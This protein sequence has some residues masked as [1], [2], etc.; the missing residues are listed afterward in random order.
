MI[1]LVL[2]S[3]VYEI[4]IGAKVLAEQMADA[5]LRIEAVGGIP[6]TTAPHSSLGESAS[7][8]ST[9]AVGTDAVQIAEAIQRCWSA[10]GVL[11]L[12]DLGSAV[13][14]TELALDLL[15]DEMR[16]LCL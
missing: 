13:L 6:A 1:S 10:E 4:A 5:E 7:G 11:L 9:R 15:P 3:H 14:S 8:Q 12:I 2:V 16:D